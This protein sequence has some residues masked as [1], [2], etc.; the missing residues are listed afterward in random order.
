MSYL[1][2]TADHIE[3]AVR[4]HPGAKKSTFNGIWNDSHLKINI[5]APAVDGKANEALIQFLATF[6]HL[7]KSAILLL[8]GETSREKRIALYDID[9]QTFKTK[10]EPF[11]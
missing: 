9:A 1:K 3:I 10:I 11:L 4:I 2:E 6:F 5:Q 8:S 7:R